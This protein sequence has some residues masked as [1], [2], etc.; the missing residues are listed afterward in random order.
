MNATLA[1][2]NNKFETLTGSYS[3]KFVLRNT[4][5]IRNLLKLSFHDRIVRLFGQESVRTATLRFHSGFPK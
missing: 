2:T 5:N 4:K 1:N 3:T